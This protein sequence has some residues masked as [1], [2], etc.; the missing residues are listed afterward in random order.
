MIKSLIGALAT[1]TVSYGVPSAQGESGTIWFPAE[2]LYGI[3]NYESN[4]NK[5]VLIKSDGVNAIELSFS[6]F[7]TEKCCDKVT[8]KFDQ[9]GAF[10]KSSVLFPAARSEYQ[11]LNW[12]G[13]ATGDVEIVTKTDRSSTEK[14]YKLNWK[15]I[16]LVE[17]PIVEPISYLQWVESLAMTTVNQSEVI[18][19]PDEL[20]QSV[21]SYLIA[22]E[23]AFLK[24][25]EELK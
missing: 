19:F 16:P 11:I 5:S 4:V 25:L 1:L 14:G 22:I 8:I 3:E 7:S 10:H 23:T 18:W 9:L 13:Y 24:L 15:R 2:E 12:I 20:V 17:V 21:F 6:E